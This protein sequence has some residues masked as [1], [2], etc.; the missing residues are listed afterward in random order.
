MSNQKSPIY[1]STDIETNGFHIGKNSILSLASAAYLENKTL[2]STFTINLD[3]LP[4]GQESAVTMDWWQQYPEAWQAARHQCVSPEVGMAQYVNWLNQLPG[5]PIFVGYPIAFDF[6]FVV[7]YLDRFAGEN[8]FGF[9]AIDLRSLAMGLHQVPF[10]KAS[11]VHWPT[12][13]FEKKPHTHIALDDAL[14]QG[15]VFC[16]MI[17]E[18]QHQ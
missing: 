10:S 1:V 17:A 2:V 9:S 7:Y 14:E 3:T 12:H 5:C 16:N 8:P 18:F 6:S 11:K 4:G 13:W 15:T